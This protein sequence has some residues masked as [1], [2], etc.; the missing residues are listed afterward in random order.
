MVLEMLLLI[1]Y[2]CR[3]SKHI[4]SVRLL[5]SLRGVAW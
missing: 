2:I 3:I 1:I 5:K 4:Q